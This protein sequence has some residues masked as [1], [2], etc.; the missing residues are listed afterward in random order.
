MNSSNI[1]SRKAK[2]LSIAKQIKTIL[3]NSFLGQ[4]YF[5][6]AIMLREALFLNSYLLNCEAWYS[7]T[8]HDIKQ[9]EAA[10]HN[11]IRT[12]ILACPRYT[13]ICSMFIELA[14]LLVRYIVKKRRILFLQY[15][16]KQDKN[17][18]LLNFF[19]AQHT[20]PIKGDWATAVEK[21]MS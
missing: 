19:Q 14:L 10:D 6:A 7:V 4:Y 5:E 12:A 2:G 17:S 16:L 1:K 18:L 20:S 15:I 3:E 13:P 21:D 9:L 11:L 8:H